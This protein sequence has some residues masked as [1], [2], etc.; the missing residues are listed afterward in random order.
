MKEARS[1]TLNG[2]QALALSTLTSS[3]VVTLVNGPLT[4]AK[5]LTPL[6][7]LFAQGFGHH[8][9]GHGAVLLALFLILTGVLY[10]YLRGREVTVGVLVKL[11]LLLVASTAFMLVV[12]L[13]F[14]VYEYFA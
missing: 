10:A 7:Q 11:A 9:V 5:E 14:Y 4:V 13:G 8:W 2:R 6:K 1:L 12:L 3:I